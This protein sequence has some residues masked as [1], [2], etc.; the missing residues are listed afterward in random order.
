MFCFLKS[1]SGVTGM[2]LGYLIWL[3]LKKKKARLCNTLSQIPLL[4]KASIIFQ[5]CHNSIDMS[6]HP[7][8]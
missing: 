7:E 3:V 6:P 1:L 5:G 2:V 4:T 8:T